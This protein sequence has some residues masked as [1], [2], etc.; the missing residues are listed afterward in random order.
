MKEKNIISDVL[1]EAPNRR[2][3]LRK[4][5]MATAA[6]GA[7]LATGGLE[8]RADPSSPTP[9]DVLQ[10]ALNLEYLESEFYTVATLGKTIEQV[11]IGISGS[12]NTGPTTGGK[13]VNFANNLVFTGPVAKQIGADER[14]HVTLLRDAFS[15]AGVTPI[16]KLEIALDDRN[17]VRERSQFSDACENFRGYRSYRVRW[18]GRGSLF[19]IESLPWN[20]S[21]YISYRSGARRQHTATGRAAVYRHQA[22]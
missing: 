15:K 22:S 17:R 16:A 21:A 10:F 18:R 2:S 7:A 19:R 5:G 6:A 4:L 1:A 12:G 14:A 8:L 9:V 3:L 20:G 11:G 13:M